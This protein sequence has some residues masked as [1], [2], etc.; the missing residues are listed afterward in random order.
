MDP[1]SNLKTHITCF[2]KSTYGMRGAEGTKRANPGLLCI[3]VL[4]SPQ[5]QSI[6]H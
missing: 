3:S 1:F 4:L 5:I 6:L 2:Q